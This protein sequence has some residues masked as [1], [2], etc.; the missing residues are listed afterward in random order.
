[1]DPSLRSI[2]RLATLWVAVALTVMPLSA[3]GQ[4]TANG[5]KQATTH[6]ANEVSAYPIPTLDF[7]LPSLGAPEQLTTPQGTLEMFV[8]RSQ[9][10][11][12]LQAAHALNLSFASLDSPD[13]AARLARQL[14]AV[15]RSEVTIDW[16]SIPDTPDGRLA[17]ADGSSQSRR[18]LNLGQASLDGRG[19]GVLRRPLLHLEAVLDADHSFGL[20]SD[21]LGVSLCVVSLHGST[22]GHDSFQ[23]VNIDIELVHIRVRC[24][25]CLD[26]R[27]DPA[28]INGLARRL[29]TEANIVDHLADALR[30]PGELRCLPPLSIGIDEPAETNHSVRGVH[31]DLEDV[32]LGIRSQLR[33]HIR[34]DPRIVHLLAGRLGAT[35][36][37]E[38]KRHRYQTEE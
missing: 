35:A 4:S 34:R 2:S 12:W 5:E 23:N 37:A 16:A 17:T 14:D 10:E 13:D 30:S 3:R 22:E 18:T 6:P 24:Q 1:M 32:D 28:V 33:C 36:A 26:L 29:L 19:D 20:P 38:Q 15:I 11:D 27:G 25:L 7:G 8:S 31:I 21:L 9:A